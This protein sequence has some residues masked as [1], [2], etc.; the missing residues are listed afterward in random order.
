MWIELPKET[1]SEGE[2]VCHVMYAAL[3]SQDQYKDQTQTGMGKEFSGVTSSGRRVMGVHC[4][5]SSHFNWIILSSNLKE[6]L[7]LW[8]TFSFLLER[9]KLWLKKLLPIYKIKIEKCYKE[10]LF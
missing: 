5:V 8:I 10:S 4:P 2:E 1:A 3:T 6:N 7:I 9:N